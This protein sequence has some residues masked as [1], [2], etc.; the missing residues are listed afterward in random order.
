[1]IYG[2]DYYPE[3]WPIERWPV[4]FKLMRDAGIN[5]V[6]VAEFAW[7]LIEPEEGR[8]EFG[9]LDRV[10]ELAEENNLSVIM[11]TP[12]ATP[13]KWLMD[14]YPEIYQRDEYQNLRGFGSRRHYC[15]NSEI[16]KQYSKKIIKAMAQ[17]Y[18]PNKNIIAWQLDNE[19]GCHNTVRC[20]CENCAKAFSQWLK[21]KYGEIS[22]LN[23]SLGMAFWGQH[24]PSFDSVILPAHT[25]CDN[26]S[27]GMLAHNPGL[28]LDY[29]RFASDSVVDYS[30][31]QISELKNS[32]V[33]VPITHNVMG[34]FHDINYFDLSEDLDFVSWD[35]Y[36]N[37]AHGPFSSYREVSYNHA[38][39]RGYKNKKFWVMEQSSGQSGWNYMLSTPSPDQLRLWVYQSVSQGADG[40]VFF[41]W[42]PCL[43]GTEQ[44][45]HGILNHDGSC[46][47]RYEILK[48]TG[49]ELDKINDVIK[50]TEVCAEVCILHSF[51]NTWSHYYQKHSENFD[52]N[53]LLHTMHGAL[54][55][56]GITCDVVGIDSDLSKYKLVI[57]P[58]YNIISK[59]DS[60]KLE[61]F[62]NDGGHVLISFRSG[63]R[64]EHNKIN[65]L[66]IPGH[67]SKMCGIKV[68]D[69]DAIGNNKRLVSSTAGVITASTWC[70]IIKENDSAIPIAEYLDGF[71]KGS[72][73][74]T[75][76]K[77]GL[78][79]VYYMGFDTNTH[80]Y[81]NL[82]N[83]IIKQACVNK[84]PIETTPGVEVI[85]RK[86][87]V[88][89]YFF[90]LNHND[91]P[92]IISLDTVLINLVSGEKHK[93]VLRLE[94]FDTAVL[95]LNY[96]EESSSEL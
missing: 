30:N 47:S 49:E 57:L 16:F 60:L 34:S 41:R 76:N 29:C 37:L 28:F 75:V 93:S 17:R 82:F 19:F 50:N 78:G 69:Y 2:V 73:A 92:T 89:E 26:K 48:K 94:A 21:D 31:M 86:D 7:S 11:C 72:T 65:G 39:V 22:I 33:N 23:E 13:P 80:S 63:N 27:D 67:L 20:Y 58:A 46:G 59:K 35:C 12:T 5:V 56:L 95:Y 1:M 43:F 85:T 53:E 9:W 84:P 70:D 25:V 83:L 45:W 64:D 52:Y 55:E 54:S 6:R 24:Y 10:L 71:Y 68:L 79:K 81:K 36:P 66:P 8:F 90:V 91:Y 18:F 40:V 4:D 38:K 15:F 87:N 61:Q 44:Y 3:H 32:G 42:R 88:N 96:K 14:K 74:A 62:A 51:D 77:T